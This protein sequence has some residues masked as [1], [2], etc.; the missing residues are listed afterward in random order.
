MDEVNFLDTA[1][2][3]LT[4]LQHTFAVFKTLKKHQ[5]LTTK[6]QSNTYNIN[7]QLYTVNHNKT[8]NNIYE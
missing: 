5:I 1:S 2:L 6:V 8:G 3:N 7:L 4:C